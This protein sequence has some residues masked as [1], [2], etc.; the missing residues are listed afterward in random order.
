M[1]WKKQ[2]RINLS[3]G[4]N[5]DEDD[6][7]TQAKGSSEENLSEEELD[8]FSNSS[9]EHF[10]REKLEKSLDSGHSSTHIHSLSKSPQFKL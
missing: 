8:D 4:H 1:K 3:P 10:M 6:P 2:N 7:E 5:H 9:A